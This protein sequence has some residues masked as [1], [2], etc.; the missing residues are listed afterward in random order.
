MRPTAPSAFA[1][2]V[3]WRPGQARFSVMSSPIRSWAAVFA[4]A[5]RPVRAVFEYARPGIG[6]LIEND[7]IRQIRPP[8]G[9]AHVRDRGLHQPDRGQQVRV[10]R[11]EHRVVLHVEGAGRWGTA[12][13]RDQDVQPAEPL[14]G[15]RDQP[16]GGVGL[17][18]VRRDREDLAGELGRRRLQRLG[19][20]GA[21][22]DARTL[23]RHRKRRT[24]SEPL[25]RGGHQRDLPRHPQIH[26]GDATADPGPKRGTGV[27]WSRCPSA[28][29]FLRSPRARPSSRSS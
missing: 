26:R 3:A 12:G 16:G 1:R 9:G 13:V 22:G 27:P 4:H 7:V 17:G 20:P 18:H 10:D 11:G 15:R 8:A 28:G 14:D 25:R 19:A 23:A 21:D 6:C 24:A 29:S 5:H 2:S